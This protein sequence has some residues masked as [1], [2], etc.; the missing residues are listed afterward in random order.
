MENKEGS[1]SDTASGSADDSQPAPPAGGSEAAAAS[2]PT[3]SEAG[4][5]TP[6]VGSGA[7]TPPSADNTLAGSP[8]RLQ[9]LIN[10]F[11]APIDFECPIPKEEV[12]EMVQEKME[13]SP[14]LSQDKAELIVDIE[15]KKMHF[16]ELTSAFQGFKMACKEIYP[17][18]E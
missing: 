4:A 7:N 17:E 2:N 10:M 13:E 6:A 15:V 18:V 8:N 16:N 1:T 14:N 11:F 12:D 9:A 3:G 5:A